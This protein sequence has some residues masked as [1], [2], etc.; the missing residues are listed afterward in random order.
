MHVEDPETKQVVVVEVPSTAK[1]GETFHVQLPKVPPA[2]A[3]VATTTGAAPP[4][5]APPVQ[6]VPPPV[7][8]VQGAQPVQAVPQ[9]VQ[10]AQPMAAPQPHA[11]FGP[12]P[13]TTQCP[14]CQNVVVTRIEKNSGLFAWGSC[15]GLACFGCIWG[16]CL[17]PFCV[18][19]FKDTKH[20]CPRCGNLI[21]SKPVIG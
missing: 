16:C 19:A 1:P 15:I 20:F 5:I 21:A 12:N 3:P 11:V 8:V 9:P 4:P 2:A 13:V 7:T 10:H 17:I 6:T 14:Q 18:D